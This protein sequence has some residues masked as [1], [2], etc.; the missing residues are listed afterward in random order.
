MHTLAGITVAR[1]IPTD[2]RAEISSLSDIPA[3][4]TQPNH[5]V[6]E[7]FGGVVEAEIEVL[8]WVGGV[9]VAWDTGHN[10][11]IWQILRRVLLL[12]QI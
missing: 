1:L 3:S 12:Q 7:G 10:D 11:M 2:H 5:E 6:V 4:E 8:G 9:G